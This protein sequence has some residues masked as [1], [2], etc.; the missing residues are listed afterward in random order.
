MKANTEKILTAILFLILLA[1]PTQYSFDV[2]GTHLS[3]ADPL[4]WLGGILFFFSTAGR[5]LFAKGSDQA[6]GRRLY[7]ALKEMLPF[8]E[9][10]LF[11]ALIALS[12]VNAENKGAAAKELIQVVE[13]V[14]V[15]FVLFCRVRL[16]ETILAKAAVVFLC[17]VSFVVLMAAVQYF[18]S[19]VGIMG[20]KGSFGNRNTYGGFLAACLPLVL[21]AAILSGRIWVKL[22]CCAILILAGITLL[23]GAAAAGLLLAGSVV[24][25]FA[26][27][28]AFFIWA[29]II[30]FSCVFILPNLPR[31]NIEEI[32]RSIRMFDDEGRPEPRY[33]EW[34]ASV[35]MWSEKPL[36]GV[37]LGNY[38][39]QIGMNYGFLP[40]KEGPKEP[41]HNNLFLVFGS[42][43]GLLG[44][45]GL[46]TML[47]LWFQRAIHGFFSSRPQD[48]NSGGALV[49]ILSLGAIGAIVGFCAA[50]IWTA[51]LV[52]GVF[53][54]FVII[55]AAAIGCKKNLPRQS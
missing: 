50:S 12:L 1:A 51:L 13:Y 49:R 28:R 18:D 29:A 44:L 55:V 24:C 2:G 38:Q 20:V 31:K 54:V 35:Q 39:S 5:A 4:I 37:G 19:T 6:L 15:A 32:N 14:V 16:G 22:W 33:T 34:Q 21:S 26:S 46:F 45:L 43:T 10:I 17:I 23:S 25:A 9:N 41:D 8:P 53:L 30:A 11:V 42:S 52:R 36:L 47:L 48:E 7:A 3:V 40:V 27:R